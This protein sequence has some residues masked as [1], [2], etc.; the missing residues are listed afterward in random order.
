MKKIIFW[1]FGIIMAISIIPITNLTAGAA[2]LK[3]GDFY[4]QVIDGKV[5][6]TSYDGTA[7]VLKI[8]EKIDGKWVTAIKNNA[9]ENKSY[10]KRVVVPSTVRY[11]GKY[12]LGYDFYDYYEEEE[13]S[14]CDTFR[15]SNFIVYG[16]VDSAAYKYCNK[17]GIAFEDVKGCG[18]GK[19]E[20][21]AKKVLMKKICEKQALT[22]YTQCKSCG[23]RRYKIVGNVN[24]TY[25]ENYKKVIR[26]ATYF[27]PEI[28]ALYCIDCKKYKQF[29][30]ETLPVPRPTGTV[31]VSKNSVTFNLKKDNSKYFAGYKVTVQWVG[32][33]Y[34]VVGTYNF[35]GTTLTVPNLK[36]GEKYKF[37]VY[38]KYSNGKKTAYSG[39]S[40]SFYK[41][42]RMEPI[43]QKSGD[44]YYQVVDG[45]V[46]ITSYVGTAKIVNVPAKIDG[47]WVTAIKSD[48]FD[49]NSRLKKV[50]VPSTVRYIGKFALS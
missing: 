17:Y 29:T 45:K 21:T 4:Y 38:T 10:L 41:P 27:D 35:K 8:P 20:W 22:Y 42:I 39:S 48:A 1:V 16:E 7:K 49:K 3:S 46:R 36:S 31:K 37:C 28:I 30:C 47:K 11:I 50:V 44:F 26:K 24:H 33:F 12:A 19:H 9:F 18:L 5:K 40:F 32:G 25:K 13:L 15:V 14:F 2:D 43:T 34:K 6:I 23:S